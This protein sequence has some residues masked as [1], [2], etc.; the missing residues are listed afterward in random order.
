MVVWSSGPPEGI[1]SA[2]SD[3]PTAAV[4]EE[5]ASRAALP[6]VTFPTPAQRINPTSRELQFIVPLTDG[7]AFLGEI[8][9]AV[10]PQDKLSV[11]APRF[12]QILRPIVKPAAYDRLAAAV[13]AAGRLDENAM[14][15]EQIRLHYDPQTLALGIAIAVETRQSRTFNLTSRS[16]VGVDNLKPAPFSAFLNV[17]AAADLTEAGPARGLGA[18]TAAIDAAMR[19]RGVVAEFEGYLSGR[20]AGPVLRRSGSRLVYDDV[21]RAMRWTLGDTQ[22]Q[23]RQFQASPALLGL[24]VSR[25][26]SRL[27]PQRE[28]RASGSQSFSVLSQSVIETVVNGRSVE[29]RTVQAGSYSLQDFPLAE[30]ANRVKL[31]IEDSSGKVR[32]VDF[33]VY[34]NQSLLAKGITEFSAFGGVYTQPGRRGIDYSR[35]WVVGGFARKGVTEQVTAGLN[36]QVNARVRQA[37]AEVL[38]GSPFG[39][40]GF[41]ISA[42]DNAQRGAGLAAALT[43]ERLLSYRGGAR[44]QSIRANVEWRSRNF[45]IPEVQF[46]PPATQL[47]ASAGYVATLGE[48]RFVAADLDYVR[49]RASGVSSYGA[50]LSGGVP[51]GKV[52]ATA[53]LGLNRGLPR[54][55]AYLRVGLRMRFGQRGAVQVDA[56]TDGRTRANISNS[57]GNG[58]GAWFGSAD[59]NRDRDAGSF[60]ASGTLVTNRAEVGIQQS[61]GWQNAAMKVTDGRT[62]LRGAFSLAFA[63]GSF[64]LGRPV[65]EA[66]VIAKAHRTLNHATIYLDPV[67]ASESARSDKLGPAL[68][69]QLSAYNFRTMAFQVPAAPPGYDLGAGNIAIKPAYRAG[70]KLEIGSDYHLLVI[71]RLLDDNGEP[72]SLLAGTA[73]DLDAPQRPALT[74][75]TAR[76]GR[77]GAQGLR[78]GRWR[79]EMPTRVPTVFEFEVRDSADGTVRLGNLRPVSPER[80]AK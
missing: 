21:G 71:G 4:Q 74:V 77:F 25:L 46:G 40:A 66:F 34:A 58:N 50:R 13:D 39:L 57:G 2:F 15:R 10:S 61:V 79:I 67:G 53:E 55:E 41:S 69:G 54:S 8:E 32:E 51:L 1:L 76:D 33:S 75:F 48:D 5:R 63:D 64:A 59:I 19:F 44:S 60:T 20:R 6:E 16:D 30:G 70:Y 78:A 11:G 52:A 45:T 7:P 42:S 31:H 12:L 17:H 29:R 26:Y 43:Y 68:F 9:L 24:G 28:I 35:D 36:A 3:P 80:N 27:D 62:T 18:P 22:F 65:T 56:G 38:W 49:D 47:R 23:A 14:G 37:G 72:I 73:N